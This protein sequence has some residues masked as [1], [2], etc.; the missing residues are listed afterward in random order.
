MDGVRKKTPERR[1]RPEV[2]SAVPLITKIQSLNTI[3]R[4]IIEIKHC[5]KSSSNYKYTQRAAWVYKEQIMPDTLDCAFEETKKL[6][7]GR[8]A[9]RQYIL[10]LIQQLIHCLVELSL[11]N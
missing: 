8:M 5:Q 1:L 3:K 2:H 4:S 6:R 7:M 11:Q 10:I 9:E